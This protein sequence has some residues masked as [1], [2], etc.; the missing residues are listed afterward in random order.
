MLFIYL[1]F[2]FITFL[3]SSQFGSD[4]RGIENSQCD[5]SNLKDEVQKQYPILDYCYGESTL[6]L[7]SLTTV[8]SSTCLEATI[9]ASSYINQHCKLGIGQGA[10]ILTHNYEAYSK[11]ADTKAASVVCGLGDDGKTLCLNDFRRISTQLEVNINNIGIRAGKSICTSCNRK[12][13]DEFRSDTSRL[14]TLYYNNV[15]D[16]QTLIQKLTD[17]CGWS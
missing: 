15:F 16:P 5:R 3:E 7:T 13:F 1:L 8:C 2:I 10:S 9:N 6:Y 11:W 17:Y 4:L 14:P 12:M